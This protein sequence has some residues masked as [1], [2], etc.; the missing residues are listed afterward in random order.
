MRGIH[1]KANGKGI[2]ML[3]GNTDS[4]LSTS[5]D[6]S[7]SKTGKLQMHHKFSVF[8]PLALFDPR[9]TLKK[10]NLKARI[11]RNYL[12]FWKFSFSYKW[13]DLILLERNASMVRAG[14][15]WAEVVAFG[16]QDCRPRLPVVF[17]IQLTSF[18]PLTYPVPLDGRIFSPF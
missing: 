13:K 14:Q 11:R 9:T 1:P 12:K 3:N 16:R 17:P 6:K 18:V 8:P 2:E 5:M 15:S 4:Y 10:S 7:I